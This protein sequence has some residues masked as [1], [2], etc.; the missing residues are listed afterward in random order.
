MSFKIIEGWIPKSVTARDMFW[1]SQ[2]RKNDFDTL[3][4]EGVMSKLRG[5]KADWQE[6]EYPPKKVRITVVVH[7]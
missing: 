2:Y 4:E 6:D 1:W 3:T 5:K 7:D